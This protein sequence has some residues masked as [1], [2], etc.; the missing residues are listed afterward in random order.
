MKKTLLLTI[1]FYQM[2]MVKAQNPNHNNSNFQN[3]FSDFKPEIRTN[4]FSLGQ[5]KKAKWKMSLQ[6]YPRVDL[7][8]KM[9][10]EWFYVNVKKLS[11]VD[12]KNSLQQFQ[13]FFFNI[14]HNLSLEKN[15]YAE[16]EVITKFDTISFAPITDILIEK[17]RYPNAIKGADLKAS[18]EKSYPGITKFYPSIVF[19]KDVTSDMKLEYDKMYRIHMAGTNTPQNDNPKLKLSDISQIKAFRFRLRRIDKKQ[20]ANYTKSF[21]EIKT[22]GSNYL[23]FDKANK[24]NNLPK[25]KKSS[26][27]TVETESTV[28]ELNN[29]D[30]L[31]SCCGGTCPLPHGH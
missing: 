17:T 29:D 20:A 9:E 18:L 16:I 11:S 3:V 19:Q 31:N 7:G 24:G 23:V 14:V 4:Y 28:S 2:F 22:I 10:S 30:S 15:V 26:V 13:K 8:E 5:S 25:E 21:W 1:F 6:N 12:T 27:K